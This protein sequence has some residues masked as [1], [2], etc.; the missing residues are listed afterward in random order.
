MSYFDHPYVSNSDLKK[1]MQ[2]ANGVA[3]PENLQAI[4]DAGTMNHEA[5]L[6]PYKLAYREK[7]Y[8]NVATE[9]KGLSLAKRMANTVLKDDLCKKVI[10]M[11]DFKREEEHYVENI[12]G[13]KGIKCKCD[14]ESKSL[15]VIF[16]YKGLAVTSDKQFGEAIEHHDYDQSAFWYLNATKHNLYLIVGVSKKEPDRLFKRIIDRNHSL[17]HSGE[18]KA[19]NAVKTW[20]QHGFE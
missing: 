15:S 2:R 8:T 10:M 7:A 19:M 13:L 12:F 1:I 5:L 17:Y 20:L 4:F 3:E 18:I 14:G 6:E 16:E 11:P 9:V